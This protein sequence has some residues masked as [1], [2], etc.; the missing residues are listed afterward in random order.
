M[1]YTVIVPD[2]RWGI[3]LLHSPSSRF[4]FPPITENFGSIHSFHLIIALL[5]RSAIILYVGKYCRNIISS[6][7]LYFT[8]QNLISM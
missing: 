4:H 1:I 3:V 2:L 8:R 6:Y 7:I 5:E